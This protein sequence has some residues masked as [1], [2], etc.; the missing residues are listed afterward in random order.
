MGGGIPPKNTICTAD[1]IYMQNT[2][3]YKENRKRKGVL[4]YGS[5][6]HGDA[7]SRGRDFTAVVCGTE[8][9]QPANGLSGLLAAE[10]SMPSDSRA[11]GN[12]PSE[13]RRPAMTERRVRQSICAVCNKS[14]GPGRGTV[15]SCGAGGRVHTQKCLSLAQQSTLSRVS[16]LGDR[17]DLNA[18]EATQTA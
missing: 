2:L 15:L 10:G 18:T 14:V 11:V 1:T 5:C 7:E 13:G 16:A 8:G 6:D 17:L 9:L 4:R 3:L 12:F